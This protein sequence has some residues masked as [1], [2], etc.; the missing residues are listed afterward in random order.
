MA[1]SNM[2]RARVSE[3]IAQEMSGAPDWFLSDPAENFASPTDIVLYFSAFCVG[4]AHLN[5]A[6]GQMDAILKRVKSIMSHWHS[7]NNNVGSESADTKT[8]RLKNEEK[9]LVCVYR[10]LCAGK[11]ALSSADAADLLKISEIEA[12]TLLGSLRDKGIISRSQK[13]NRWRLSIG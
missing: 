10:A 12:N 4:L 2:D 3:F 13:A 9:M 11:G 8:L 7:L 1:L 6:L 5:S